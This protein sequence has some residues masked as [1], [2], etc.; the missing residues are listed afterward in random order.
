[1][2]GSDYDAFIE[3]FVSAVRERWPQALL[4]WEDFAGANAARLLERYRDQLCTFND[5]IQSTAAIAAATLIAAVKA[6]GQA[7]ADQRI[8]L[9][10][11]GAAGCGIANLLLQI[12]LA[13][14][15]QEADARRRFFAVDHQGLLLAETPHTT[16]AQAPFLQPDAAI[17]DWTLE[18]AAEI[19]LLDVVRNVRP[20]VLIGASGQTGAFTEIV[21]RTMADQ[22]ERPI[23]FPLSNPIS[24]NEAT[25]QD[26]IAWTQGRAIANARRASAAMFMAACKAV[27]EM[28]P[29]HEGR[30]L[31]PVSALRSGAKTVAKAVAQQAIAEGLSETGSLDAL[32]ASI[33]RYFWEPLYRAYEKREASA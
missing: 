4:H 18:T 25:A 5:D 13:A 15:A 10:G 9:F 26:L 23:I 1:V 16:P 29:T 14:G 22:V 11:A 28:S 20:T 6:T 31:P 27:V 8:I 2:T 33:E 12:M 24:K 17:K 32:D 30:L 21:V 19:S 7:L 3:E